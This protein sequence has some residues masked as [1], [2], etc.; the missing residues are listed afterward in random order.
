MSQI[1]RGREIDSMLDARPRETE[2]LKEKERD[3]QRQPQR[4]TEMERG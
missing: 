2:G 1:K 3:I 4:G